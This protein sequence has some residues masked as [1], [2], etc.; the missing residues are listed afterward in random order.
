M[1]LRSPARLERLAADA[2]P[3]TVAAL[4]DVAARVRA[5]AGA[6]PRQ[7]RRAWLAVLAVL[8]L[9]P[10]VLTVTRAPSFPASVE[11]FPRRVGPYSAMTQ[12]GYYRR[13]LLDA[14]LRRETVRNA[15]AFPREITIASGGRGSLRVTVRTAVHTRAPLMAN[16]LARQI[17][18][19]TRR[20]LLAA[21]AR[22]IAT[23][24]R[25]LRSGL[26]TPVERRRLSAAIRELQRLLPT[27]PERVVLGPAPPPP[28]LTRIGDRL[29]NAMPGAFP[30]RPD[31]AAAGLAGLLLAVTLWAIALVL[32]PPRARGR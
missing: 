4:L 28:R 30:H 19:A 31:P 1:K 21:I 3:K 9:G 15:G 13:L 32:F 20:D 2:L 7:R 6:E 26:Y 11:L 14:E 5:G 17:A 29:A 22:D 24:R 25:K 23:S 16:A 27:P 12:P 10:I 18:G 8:T